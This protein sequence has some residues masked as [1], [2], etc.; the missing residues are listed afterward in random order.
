V[1]G[2][3]QSRT[4]PGA[5]QLPRPFPFTHHR[6]APVLDAAHESTRLP[7]ITYKALGHLDEA[8][9]R[10]WLS[11]R[12]ASNYFSGGKPVSGVRYALPLSRRSRIAASH[13]GRLHHRPR[14]HRRAAHRAAQ[15]GGAAARQGIEGCGLF[16]LANRYSA[17]PT[18]RLCAITCAT[19]AARAASRAAWVLTFAPC[20]REK[21]LAFLRW[22]GVNV[23]P[24][25]ERAILGAAIRSPNR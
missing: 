25:T 19:A 7:A 21:T 2:L 10:T 23:A 6:P 17:R 20:G 1:G 5:T 13:A 22:L 18:Q 14:G 4:R 16:H 9:W 15:R 3:R 24:D 12:R 11:Q 8:G